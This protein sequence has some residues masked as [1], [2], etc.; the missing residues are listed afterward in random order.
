MPEVTEQIEGSILHDIKQLIGQE[1]DDP[2]FDLDLRIFVNSV[3]LTLQQI[4][5]GPVEGFEITGPHETWDQLLGG[6]KN[7]VAAKT[8]VLIRTRLIFDPPQTGPLSASLEEQA[9]RIEYRLFL[10]MD[11][12]LNSTP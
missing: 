3:F 10:Q 4:G 11:P 9:A 5:V 2:T 6:D 8:L 1:W 12:P 7:L